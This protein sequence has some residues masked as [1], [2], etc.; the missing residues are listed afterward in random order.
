MQQLVRAH[1]GTGAVHAAP[2]F[3]DRQALCGVAC[4]PHRPPKPVLGA[5]DVTCRRCGGLVIRQLGLTAVTDPTNVCLLVVEDGRSPMNY[6]EPVYEYL[7]RNAGRDPASGAL[8]T[9]API[10]GWLSDTY[11][12]TASQAKNV[13]TR[14][15]KELE[16]QGRVRREHRYTAKVWITD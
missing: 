10:H 5:F 4:V 16:R 1:S 12:L 11:G 3:D 13:R 7:R 6:T 15:V 9:H 8:V 14:A 2:V